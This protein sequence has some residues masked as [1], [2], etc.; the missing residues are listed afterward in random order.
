MKGSG[1][2]GGWTPRL[3]C[4]GSSRTGRQTWGGSRVW[5][6]P[7]LS[8]FQGDLGTA[9]H[10]LSVIEEPPLQF[11][12]IRVA[13]PEGYVLHPDV[14]VSGEV[15]GQPLDLRKRLVSTAL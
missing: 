10:F 8:P 7:L 5:V 6:R 12:E 13:R 9:K 4:T 14:A 11:G 3:L 1:S 2:R 15:E